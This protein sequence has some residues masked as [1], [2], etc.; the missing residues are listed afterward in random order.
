M[1]KLQV[2]NEIHAPVRRNFLR[3]KYKQIGILDTYEIDLI[4]IQQ[5]GPENDNHK[6][7]LIAVDIFSKVMYARAIKTKRAQDTANAMRDIF[8]KSQKWPKRIHSDRGNEFLGSPFKKLLTEYKIYLYSTYSEKKACMVERLIRT[9]KTR[10]W[11]H[12]SLS[13]SY[14]YLDVLDSIVDD[15]NNTKHRTIKMAP[16]QVSSENEKQLLE[17]VYNY[18]IVDKQKQKFFVNDYVRISRYKSV[19][20]KG[21][22]H[23]WSYEIF[24]VLK[25]QNTIPITYFLKD[26]KNESIAGAFYQY[27]LLAVL[28]PDV[29]LVKKILKR[30]KGKVLVQ[31]MGFDHEAPEWIDENSV[32]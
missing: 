28:N 23:N 18:K 27:E 32:I 7:I 2:V 30:K 8:V 11:K 12:F 5:F 17:T 3:R 10:M 15:Y 14:R 16:N 31:W 4:D 19:F 1:S 6:Y 29:Y 20:E 13:G 24:Q 9:I 26:Y 22:L 25:V 21:Y